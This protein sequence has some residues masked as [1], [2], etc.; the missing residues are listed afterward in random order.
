MNGSQAGCL[1]SESQVLH[2]KLPSSED[3]STHQLRPYLAKSYV[4]EEE[5]MTRTM[6]MMIMSMMTVM[7]KKAIHLHHHHYCYH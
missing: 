5:M 2:W 7:K 3:C 4:K 6:K 1:D